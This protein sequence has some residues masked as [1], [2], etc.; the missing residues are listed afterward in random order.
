M[1]ISKTRLHRVE[2]EAQ[3]RRDKQLAAVENALR[4]WEVPQ[5]EY[6]AFLQQKHVGGWGAYPNMVAPLERVRVACP[7][8]IPLGRRMG[9]SYSS[10]SPKSMTHNE[11]LALV[12]AEADYK[13]GN[14]GA[15]AL[16]IRAKDDDPDAGNLVKAMTETEQK[17]A[18]SLW[19]DTKPTVQTW[20]AIE[21]V[22]AR[23]PELVKAFWEKIK[24]L[25]DPTKA[26]TTEEAAS[27]ATKLEAAE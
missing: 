10:V 11:I 3:A 26:E 23:L 19:G 18:E 20:E 4:L 21:S 15:I 27:D 9:W 22:E 13:L 16:A 25:P 2:A 12:A 14:L 24:D 8:A 1:A 6:L 5:A 17:F 7:V